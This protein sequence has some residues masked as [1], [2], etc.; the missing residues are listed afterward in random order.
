M[1]IVIIASFFC[2]K[3]NGNKQQFI[4]V[5]KDFWHRVKSIS[6]GPAEV[7]FHNG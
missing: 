7:T 4:R 3:C 1:V 5:V 2:K 6:V